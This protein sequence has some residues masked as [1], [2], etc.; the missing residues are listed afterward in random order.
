MLLTYLLAALVLSPLYGSAKVSCDPSTGLCFET[1][2]FDV[3]GRN[4][5][6]GFAFPEQQNGFNNSGEML[7]SITIQLPYAFSAFSLGDSNL[8]LQMV[9]YA[10]PF[11]RCVST[12]GVDCGDVQQPNITFTDFIGQQSAMLPND[13]LAPFGDSVTAFSPLSPIA[14]SSTGTNNFTAIFRM[15]F[16]PP[17]GEIP[18]IFTSD[19]KLSLTATFSEN[20]PIYLDNVTHA[21]LLPLKGAEM[22][23]FTLDV[24]KARFANYT[25]M[26]TVAELI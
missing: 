16:F 22:F 21:A 12:D 5:E 20:F 10:F 9:L 23:P 2:S 13:T 18:E 6:L 15:Q 17:P 26:L 4:F 11:K 19:G 25:D 7:A 8:G 1:K 14:T 3:E 24:K